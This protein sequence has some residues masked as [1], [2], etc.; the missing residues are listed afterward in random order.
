MPFK[1]EKLLFIERTI[2][3]PL[4]Y[5]V[6]RIQSFIMQKK[7]AHIEPL[8]SEGLLTNYIIIYMLKFLKF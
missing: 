2:R 3:N 7:V 6:G 1:G 4:M 8:R 5:S